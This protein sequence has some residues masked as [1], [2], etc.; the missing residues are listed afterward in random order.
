MNPI[1]A[2]RWGGAAAILLA[3]VLWGRS[4]G[5]DS[6]EAKSRAAIA[7]KDRALQVAEG[8]LR[9]SEY[10]L[11]AAA[12]TLRQIDQA[13][14]AAV[15]AATERQRQADFAKERAV[16]AAAALKKQIGAIESDL[17]RAK[18]D[19]DCKRLLEATSCASLQ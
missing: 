8:E 17:D 14:A 12:S 15:E 1:T 2:L 7:T 10:A 3:L 19:P 11:Q 6:A 18:L 4:C 13:T 16:M 5:V 9:R